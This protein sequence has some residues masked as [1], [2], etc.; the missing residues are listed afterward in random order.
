[1]TSLRPAPQS[2]IDVVRARQETPG[3]ERVLHF[4]NAGSALTPTPVLD[5][6]YGHLRAEAEMGGYEAADAAAQQHRRTYQ[7]IAELLGCGTEEIALVENA[8]RAW[9]MAFY[10]MS[11]KPGDR[12]LTCEAEYV[13]NY[14][15]YMQVAGQTGAVVEVVPSDA[16]GQISLDALRTELRR[17]GVALVGLTHVPTNGGLVNPAEEVGKLTREAGVPFLLDACQSAGQ[18][19]LNVDALGCDMLSVTGRK[20][21]RGPRGT[22]FLYVRREMI[23]RLDPPFLDMRAASWTARNEYEIHPTARR[24][25][26]WE[27]YVAGQI[28]LGAAVEYVL[29][30]GIDSIQARVVHLAATLRSALSAMAGVQ[31]RDIGRHKCGIVTFTVDDREPEDLRSQ[32]NARGVNVS[33]TDRASSRIDMEARGLQSMVRASVHYYNTEDEVERFASEVAALSR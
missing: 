18:W 25:E 1:M 14:I 27:S 26:N 10:S 15:A 31:V 24:F 19:P 23:E 8:T 7:A 33:V 22:G 5:A 13:S 4:N 20:Y 17:G 2:E 9:D 30:W 16:D 12:I 28:A 32:L 6:L 29:E 11:F 21:L 3:A